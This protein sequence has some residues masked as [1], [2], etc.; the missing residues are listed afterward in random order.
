LKLVISALSAPSELNGVSRHAANIVKGLLSWPDVPEIHFLAGA[1]QKEMYSHA[2]G[3]T[4]L[5][6]RFHWLPVRHRNLD[7]I[8]W[9]YHELP[10]L[11]ARLKADLVHLAY[12][13]PLRGDGFNCPTLV[14]LHDL[15]PFDIP[16]NFGFLKGA[17]NRQL[18]QQCLRKVSA[19]ACVSSSTR[20]RLSHWLGPVLSRKA[21]TIPNA[22]EPNSDVSA[23]GPCGLQAEQPFL[24][25]IAQHRRNKN[26]Q[27]SLRIFERLTRNGVISSE[28]KLVIVGIPG[29]ETPKINSHIYQSRLKNNVILLSG[30]T[31]PELL[32]CYRNCRLLLAPSSIEGFGLPVVEGLL[33]GSP[34][35]CSDIPAFREVGTKRCRYIK[36]GDQMLTEYESAIRETLAGPRPSP[37]SLPH[38]LPKAI[39]RQ[40]MNLYHK[41]LGYRGVPPESAIASHWSSG[42]EELHPANVRTV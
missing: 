18:M 14:S 19:I 27:L 3:R 29:P 28:T 40:Y 4:D 42:T 6:L 41:L 25:C 5:Q 11:A 16:S 21:V 26:I 37:I 9:Y 2:I 34:L 8:L 23:S 13:M 38:L 7:R 33:A 20:N 22:V 35:V 1:W 15:Y 32:W 10:K 36:F 17:V 24:L 12:T 39:A 30:I 31:D